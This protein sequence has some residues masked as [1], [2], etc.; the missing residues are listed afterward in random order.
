LT[1]SYT[2]QI[3]DPN[4]LV[5]AAIKS[6]ITVD[7]QYVIGLISRYLSWNGT[8]DFAVEI[9]PAAEL[10]WSDADG[11]LPSIV[12]TSWTGRAW[13]NDTLTEALTGFDPNPNRPDAGL[14]IYLA[15]DGT[16]RNYGAPVWFDPNPG[17]E[18]NP[19]VPAGTD[20]FVGILTHEIFHSLGFINYTQEWAAKMVAA[21]DISYFTGAQSGALFGGAIPFRT[22]FDH[23]GYA[24]DP[25]IPISR[26]LMYEIGNYERNRFD[27]GRIDLA[28]LADMGYTIKS[29]DGL[30][31]FEL[32]DTATSLTGTGAAETL[33]GDYHG[34]VLS[35]L[36]GNDR[37]DAGAG[38]DQLSG[39]DGNDLL[40]GGPGVD[41]FDGGANLGDDPV[42]VYGDRISFAE[43]SATQGAVADL[44]TGIISNDGFGNSETMVNI[45]SL[46]AGTAFGDTFNGDDNRN[47]LLGSKG[48]TLNGHGGDDII[49]IT[50]AAAVAGGAGTDLLELF[51]NGGFYLPDG[52]GD[53]MAELAQAM[54][55][56]WTV[57]LGL[58]RI[59]DGY[60][61][62][63][64]VAGIEN[65]TASAIGG[66]IFGDD[67]A[68]VLT[69]RS[70]GD[71]LFGRGGADTLDG[72]DGP[73]QLYGGAGD[74]TI[75]GGAASDIL[76]VDGPG[77]DVAE[78]GA[79]DWDRLIVSYG[80]A[81][82]NIVMTMPA[83]Y[84]GGG[85]SGSIAGPDRSL[86][87]NGIEIFEVTTGSGNDIVWGAGDNSAFPGSGNVYKLGDGDDLFHSMGGTDTVDAGAGVDGFSGT[88]GANGA[89]IS[90][91]LQPTIF[92]GTQ[93]FYRNFEYFLSLTTGNGADNITT[94]DL[95][96]ADT[97]I[98]GG[99][100]DTATLWNGH[101]SVNGGAA[102][103]GA[104]DSGFDTL[105]LNYGAAT[106]G[107]H[108]VGSLT[109]NAAG[110]SGQFSD[111]S[112]RS[113]TFQAIDRFL[114][115][116]GS[117]NDNITTGTGNDEIRTG[118]GADTLAAGG[119][120]DLLDGG[121]GADSMTGG[122]GDDLYFVDNES[123]TVTEAA[124]E[125]TDEVRTGLA[126]YVLA[127]NV[128]TL[129]GTAATGQNLTGN[130]GNNLLNA[131]GGNDVLHLEAG[132]DDIVNG[133]Q[134][135]DSIHF[136]ESFRA[137]DQ[138]DGGAGFDTLLLLGNY[139]AGVTLAATTL[140]DVE[141]ISLL[142][143]GLVGYTLVTNDAN[144]AAGQVL[145]I[146]GST[147][148]A[149]ETLSFDGR[150]ETNGTF[151]ITGG[152]AMD[153][154]FG[155]AGNDVFSG[156]GG[157]DRF[158]GG[159]GSDT[160]TGGAGDD[161]YQVEQAGDVVIEAAGE[162]VDEV[163]TNL[164]VY[165]LAGLA[166][167]ENLVGA[168]AAG[169]TLTGNGL[170]NAITGFTGNDVIDG[171]AGADTMRGGL[172]ND[173]YY[174][175]DSGDQAFETAG[176]GI[177]EIR[178]SLASA[179]LAAYAN[180]ENLTGT[181]ASGQT[182]TGSAANNVVTGNAGNDIL[183]L[184][185][186]G[187]DIVFAGAGNDNIFF[188]GALT[189]ADIVN[190]GAGVDTLVLQGPYGAL[191]LMANITEIENIS[192]LGG[193][194]VNFGEPGTNRYDY[195]LTTNDANF[196][197]GVQARINGS[198]LLEGEDFTFNGSA[199]TNASFVVYGGKGVDTLT[200]GLGNDIFFYAEERF[201][202]GDT[203]NGAAGYD[204][205]FLRGNY[206]I[207]FN[208]PGYTGL[209]TNIENLTLTSATD[210]RYA[211]GGGT[212]FDYALTL[213][214]AIVGA[215][216]T[217]TVSGALLMATETMI[218]DASLETNGILRLFGGKS[219]DTLKGGAQADYLHGNL[220]ADT[221]S[222]GGGAD[223]FRYDNVAESNSAS[224][225]HILDFTP[226]T[227]RI[228]LSRID[229]NTLVG[230]D[231]AFSWIGSS[232]FSGVAGQLR[233][234]ESGGSWFVEGDTNGDGVADLVIQLTLQGPTPLGVGDFI[235]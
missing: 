78:G 85:L 131:G 151:N 102:G 32:V 137:A 24:Q 220:G 95:D 27:I 150:A 48:D 173:V 11:L 212:E 109:G 180:V 75:R 232:V 224:M 98:L 17:F 3:L 154:L 25:A 49:Q 162:G 121:S 225:D 134:G 125:G 199:E 74:D 114:I 181:L 155:G 185:D 70:G 57:D 179:S 118:A 77:T 186:G 54:V 7:A 51:S 108:N 62:S 231:Q 194:N 34:N 36:A 218:L 8:I 206:T 211:R 191:T 37:I 99:N 215:G 205:M 14:T 88:M 87:Y 16:I 223:L 4:N 196:A 132:G 136:G 202:S 126:A 228:E 130:S 91:S 233:A 76:G 182:L 201:A 100:G 31:L 161:F 214:D 105:I 58:G 23:Y 72:G 38:N 119:G 47:A 60:G 107:V 68:N 20:D 190:G 13:T 169:M 39:G 44:R 159:G 203:V 204:G 21:G 84:P 101:D 79:G 183:R 229:A 115:A 103:A 135:N 156:G 177:D 123:D 96:R 2:F 97:L 15:D 234:F 61:N 22:G 168:R 184:Q 53:G 200:G 213:S 195:V 127:A 46:G 40:T 166:N 18:T 110:H 226:G 207:D 64:S 171:G 86:G 172:G 1:N 146:D 174:V 147:L 5:S 29:Y 120:N 30:S 52:N 28:M 59:F 141:R 90:W 187:D 188:I 165:S 192:L 153:I 167:V 230:G 210:E 160:M 235:P 73:D 56:P 113:A 144:V 133:G 83:A 152:A 219:A 158:F 55:N 193:N 227:D 35:G 42:T 66:N 93:N 71:L 208:A 104:T 198:A 69:G 94:A 170:A 65:V 142:S 117:G 145:E 140:K 221:L 139:S 92:P 217:L 26:G 50:A 138:V 80:D 82:G 129:T 122:T 189:S 112:T 176:E 67:N 19:A 10:T 6:S 148:G 197:A 45:E 63:G 106:G 164:A 157:S 111:D 128:E 116:T 9:R 89:G 43:A 12:Q 178:T 149:L 124:G 143:F 209:F 33:Y 163:D 216:Q 41:S 175:D 81:I 222:G